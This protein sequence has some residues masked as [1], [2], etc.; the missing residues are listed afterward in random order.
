MPHTTAA[1]TSCV[2]YEGRI[3]CRA[4]VLDCIQLSWV[5][6]INWQPSVLTQPYKNTNNGNIL[7]PSVSFSGSTVVST[8]AKTG[9]LGWF[10][11]QCPWARQWQRSG[12]GPWAHMMPTALKGEL[13][14]K[15][16][17]YMMWYKKGLLLLLLAVSCL[18]KCNRKEATRQKQTDR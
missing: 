10:S 18:L 13:K 7:M 1:K 6:I 11:R 3:H 2:L 14:C 9:T 12:A 8:V 15:R 5:D 17:S 4:F 16:T